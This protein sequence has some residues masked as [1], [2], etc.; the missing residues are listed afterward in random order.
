MNVPACFDLLPTDVA[1][2]KMHCSFQ[3]NGHSN[4][5]LLL[6]V[7]ET[8]SMR[9][10]KSVASYQKTCRSQ[11]SMYPRMISSSS[12]T[13]NARAI[14]AHIQ[15]YEFRSFRSFSRQQQQSPSHA[16]SLCEPSY[17]D[18]IIFLCEQNYANSTSFSI[19]QSLKTLQQKSRTWRANISFSACN[20]TFLPQN[21]VSC[22]LTSGTPSRYQE[23]ACSPSFPPANAP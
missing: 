12:I 15:A 19:Q 2:N 13:G 21:H 20:A 16:V 3:A 22:V 14:P 11:R 23:S 1:K 10:S 8:S 18:S 4:H 6:V 17:N 7:G 9:M 5:K